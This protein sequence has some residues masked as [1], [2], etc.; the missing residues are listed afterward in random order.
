[1][2][3]SRG[4]RASV[5]AVSLARCR[6]RARED[7]LARYLDAHEHRT[8]S[9]ACRR[10]AH[11]DDSTEAATATHELALLLSERMGELDI[12]QPLYERVVAIYEVGT[13]SA[14]SPSRGSEPRKRARR[15]LRGG[16]A[17]RHPPSSQEGEAS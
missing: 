16:R 8:A 1:V 15:L 17:S 2:C 6:A 7:R 5:V 14:S 10:R 13:S 4:F 11:G 9:L 12:A 3:A